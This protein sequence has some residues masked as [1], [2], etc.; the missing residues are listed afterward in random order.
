MNFKY[1]L[2]LRKRNKFLGLY[3]Q[4]F[5]GWAVKIAGLLQLPNLA[6]S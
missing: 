2:I 3:R 4:I 6:A 5:C 1:F